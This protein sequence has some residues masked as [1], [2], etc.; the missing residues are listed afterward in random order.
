MITKQPLS[1]GHEG[2]EAA[3]QSASSTEEVRL[4]HVWVLPPDGSTRKE[5]LLKDLNC[6][7]AAKT[8]TLI[9]GPT[10]SGKSTLLH[11]LAGLLPLYRG[12]VTYGPHSLWQPK[13]RLHAEVHR[14]IGIVFQ[15][16]ERQ[17]F[18]ESIE[19]EFRYSL[20]PYRLTKKA[21]AER[22]GKA[23]DRM[24]LSQTFLEESFLTLS[25][26]QKR[27]AALATTIAAE[28]Q[29][30]LL[31]EPTAGIDP[32]GIG[33]LLQMI[34]EHKQASGGGAIVISHDLDTFLPVAD[35]IILLRDGEIAADGTREELLAQPDAWLQAGVGMPSSLALAQALERNGTGI[36]NPH[37][38]NG[39]FQPME[40]FP[41]TPQAMAEAIL[42]LRASGTSRQ[43]RVD[44]TYPARE[45]SE[46]DGMADAGSS[47]GER[48]VRQARNDG[49]QWDGSELDRRDKRAAWPKE[50][51]TETG[52]GWNGDTRSEARASLHPEGAPENI[53]G[54]LH[55]I[56][57]WFV[58]IL[59]STGIL[60]QH[61]WLGI[62][63]AALITLCCILISGAAYPSLMKPA[64]PFIYFLVLSTVVSGC[65]IDFAPDSWRPERFYFS[66]PSAMATLQLLSRFL[67]VMLLGVLLAVTTGTRKMQAGLEQALSFLERFRVPVAAFTF[68]ATLL[69]RFLPM[70]FQEMDRTALIVKARGKTQGRKG[71]LRVQDVPVF[72]IPFLLSMMKHAEDLSLALEAKGY[73]LKRLNGQSAAALPWTKRE[74]LGIA[75]GIGLFTMLYI[76]ER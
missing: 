11:A 51:R 62:G 17:L 7:F 26:G 31:D 56:A 15:Y 47:V 61:S 76:A 45:P 55:P 28:P 64:K 72:L 35:R 2:K 50:T 59:L 14:A 39:R 43:T 32:Q 65:G 36:K 29:W 54:S 46:R 24:Q 13:G 42:Q 30:L 1:S 75:V 16:P 23:L 6:R 74:W 21:E 53:V 27:K 18:A 20:R 19:K 3:L 9:A 34:M 63:I 48:Q 60:L 37:L 52:A 41:V 38:T 8:I 70:L 10:G 58:Y 73:Q 57:K 67:L 66:I 25:D 49:N 12:S 22:I 4:E 69:V 40:A 44:M 68:S 5:P 71:R 33:P